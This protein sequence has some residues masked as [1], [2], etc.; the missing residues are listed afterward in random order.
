MNAGRR[1]ILIFALAFATSS[2]FL[3]AGRGDDEDLLPRQARERDLTLYVQN[4]NFY[5]ANIYAVYSGYRQRL[6]F[7][8]GLSNETF[9]FRWNQIDLRIDIQFV[10]AGSYLT[11]SLLVDEGDELEL[12]I[13]PSLHLRTRRQ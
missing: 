13:D 8:G 7:V 1:Y 10:S 11:E 12:R 2:C 5:D 6:G 4:Q 3:F 9:T